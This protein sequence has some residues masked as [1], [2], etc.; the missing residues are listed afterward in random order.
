[1]HLTN[2]LNLVSQHSDSLR[3]QRENVKSRDQQFNEIFR[4]F[5]TSSDKSET[6]KEYNYIVI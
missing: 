6:Y 1:M 3:K 5:H 2:V 4:V